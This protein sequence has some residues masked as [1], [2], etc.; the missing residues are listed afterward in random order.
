MVISTLHSI[1]YTFFIAVTPIFVAGAVF[2]DT[3]IDVH[4]VICIIKQNRDKNVTSNNI[5][6]TLQFKVIYSIMIDDRSR[7]YLHSG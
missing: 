4:H 7:L 1:D 2:R 6:V 5:W 3:D